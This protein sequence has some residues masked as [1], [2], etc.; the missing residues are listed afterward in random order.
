LITGQGIGG[1]VDSPLFYLYTL[2]S[3]RRKDLLRE[4]HGGHPS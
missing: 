3:S 4:L 2:S 1:M